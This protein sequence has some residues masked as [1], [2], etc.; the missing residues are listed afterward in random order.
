MTYHL[1][2]QKVSEFHGNYLTLSTTTGQ[3]RLGL[4]LYSHPPPAVSSRAK[5]NCTTGA[6]AGTAVDRCWCQ[7]GQRC[8]HDAYRGR[9]TLR[10]VTTLARTYAPSSMTTRG[11]TMSPLTAAPSISPM[12]ISFSL[13][14]DGP[15]P[16]PSGRSPGR[17]VGGGRR[18]SRNRWGCAGTARTRS[19][20]AASRWA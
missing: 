14:A 13:A 18:P 1:S 2:H 12:T 15:R 3:Q 8:C 10:C 6:S 16:R 19:G 5:S 7:A 9:P 20:A 4:P 11:A 17:R